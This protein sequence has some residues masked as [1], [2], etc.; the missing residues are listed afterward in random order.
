MRPGWY[1]QHN[2]SNYTC[3]GIR[4]YGCYSGTT[5]NQTIPVQV[6]SG[7][8][9]VIQVAAGGNHVLALKSDGTVLAWGANPQGQLGTGWMDNFKHNE[10]YV[11]LDYNYGS[12][13]PLSNVVSIRAWTMSSGAV[14]SDGTVLAW[15]YN[16]EAQL[17]IGTTGNYDNTGRYNV[18][19]K[20]VNTLVNPLKMG[21]SVV[22]TQMAI[23]SDGTLWGWGNNYW[24][25]LIGYDGSGP[26]PA[27]QNNPVQIQY[28]SNS[29][30]V[31]DPIESARIISMAPSVTQSAD[32]QITFLFKAGSAGSYKKWDGSAWTNTSL[33]YTSTGNTAAEVQ[34]LT[35]AQWA[36]LTAGSDLY[37]AAI[38]KN[39]GSSAGPTINGIEYVAASV[40]TLT[41][42][43]EESPALGTSYDYTATAASEGGTLAYEFQTTNGTISSSGNVASITYA[44]GGSATITA[45]AYLAEYPDVS[46][47]VTKTVSVKYDPPTVTGITCPSSL[48]AGE[49]GHCTVSATAAAGTIKYRWS[50]QYTHISSP[51]EPETDIY[52]TMGGTRLVQLDA[53]I[54]ESPES[55]KTVYAT[56]AVNPVDMSLTISCPTSASKY[57]PVTC[58]AT[59]SS[60]WGTAA[61]AWYSETDGIVLGENNTSTITVLFN[62][63]DQQTVTARLFIQETPDIYIEQTANI[64]VIVPP[65]VIHNVSCT[66]ES[67]L[68]QK[69]QCFMSASVLEGD[70]AIRWNTT[71]GVIDGPTTTSTGIT[72]NSPGQKTV[73]VSAYLPD[74][75]TIAVSETVEVTI[76]DTPITVEVDCPA[77]IIAKEE[78]TCEATGNSPWGTLAYEFQATNA[79]VE[80]AGNKATLT[81]GSKDGNLYVNV[82]AYLFEAPE[83]KKTATAVASVIGAKT[84]TPVIKGTR[85]IYID[86]DYTYTAGAPC[87]TAGTC[88]VKWNVDGQ[89]TEGD[90][91]TVKYEALGKFTIQAETTLTGTDVVTASTFPVNVVSLP[92]I[93]VSIKG[94]KA[95]FVGEEYTYTAVVPSKYSNLATVMQWTLPDGTTVDGAEI[96]LTP[97][98]EGPHVLKCSGW[99]DGHKEETIKTANYKLTAIGY[100]YPAPVINVRNTEGKGPYNTT[101][102]IAYTVKMINGLAYNINYAWDFGDGE[103]LETSNTIVHH[104]FKKVGNYTVR[105]TATD[106]YGNTNTDSVTINVGAAPIEVKL[107]LSLS[108]KYMRAPLDAYVRSSIAGKTPLDR[109]E[110]HEWKVDGVKVESTK[111]EWLRTTFAE[112]GDHVI[113]YTATMMSGATNTNSIDLSVN[114]NQPPTCTIEETFGT[115]NYVYLKAKCEDPDGRLSSYKWDLDDGRGWRNGTGKISFKASESHTYTIGLMATDD[116]GETAE[117]TK[118]LVVVRE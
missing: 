53:Y 40:N 48:N 10:K 17:G 85:T 35:P 1:R 46:K 7:L 109:L 88:T 54:E 22:N 75:P 16:G 79:S 107:K 106:Q 24:R 60:D 86:T 69:T 21:H 112:A 82:T 43:G 13:V 41:F 98:A 37:V 50:G 15:G 39:N 59:G 101:F 32:Q 27:Q 51:Q 80:Q 31:F 76:L 72:F 36:S 67:Y 29:I 5:T 111:A 38:M 47:T 28:P 110:S 99:V 62:G 65:P 4:S 74:M 116:S 58:T 19:P 92:R 64:T 12:P 3:S 14:K 83:L 114:P 2:K 11:V 81:A 23:G 44:H 96:S 71:G 89:E 66:P 105:M 77:Y 52:F 68:G 87:I 84:V 56:V 34:A 78:F 93:P 42:E 33:T 49:T 30:T 26:S 57:E 102:R 95:V 100:A 73:T 63:L 91:L 45:K 9:D 55:V 20:T 115:G 94:Q 97:L 104:V 90:T 108:N 6:S 18:F 70:V 117:F 113:S 61:Y 8:T 25:V 118:E 103:T